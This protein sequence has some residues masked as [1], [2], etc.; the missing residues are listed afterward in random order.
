LLAR[1]LWD[2]LSKAGDA[3][4]QVSKQALKELQGRVPVMEIPDAQ[5]EER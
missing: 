2:R 5:R 1:G 3:C 4:T